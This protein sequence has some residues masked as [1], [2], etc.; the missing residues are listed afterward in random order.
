MDHRIPVWTLIRRFLTRIFG[1]GS[2][3][4]GQ[5]PDPFIGVRVPMKRGPGSRSSAVALQ[6]PDE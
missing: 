1:L 5:T 6:E 3:D 2:G 4:S